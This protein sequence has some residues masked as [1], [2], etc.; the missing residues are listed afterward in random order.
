LQTVKKTYHFSGALFGD[1]EARQKEAETISLWVS[2]E[3]HKKMLE[4]HQNYEKSNI[5]APTDREIEYHADRV[6]RGIVEQLE[7]VF[8]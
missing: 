4:G 6:M 1:F 8:T 5:I 3:K 2:G 7:R